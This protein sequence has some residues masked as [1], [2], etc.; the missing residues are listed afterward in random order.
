[1]PATVPSTAEALLA[2]WAAALAEWGNRPAVLAA[3]GS[4]ARTFAEVEDEAQARAADFAALPPRSIV[5]VQIGNAPDWPAVFL[6]LLRTNHLTLPLG[7]DLAPPPFADALFSPARRLTPLPAA[8]LSPPPTAVL[9]KL[10]SGTTGA[11]R[12]VW[13]TA[14]QLAADCAQICATMGITRGDV[15]FGA[16][17]LAHSYGFS[18]LLT[19]LLLR[20]VPLALSEDRLPR[21]LLAGLERTGATVF[22]GTPVLFQHLAA[23][24]VPRPPR[25]RLCISAGAPLPRATWEAFHARFGLGIHT[26][27][28]SSECGGIAYDRSGSLVGEGHVGTALEGV[29]LAPRGDGRLEV[30]S[31]AVGG[32]YF[33][34]ADPETL[35]GSRF[36]PGDLVRLT[37][38]GL[39]LTGRAGDLIN[40][41]GRK[42]N[43]A[44]VER[45][46]VQFPGVRA[47]VVF[48]VVS[49]RRGEEPVVCVAGDGIDPAALLRHCLANLPAWQAPRD[50]WL[51]P[52]IPADERGKT[53]RRRLA[54]RYRVRA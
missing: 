28:G 13:F 6:A 31:A 50:V 2:P 3:D 9:L 39:V 22:P 41:A 14:V 47:A 37:E 29:S 45:C 7:G 51:V 53:S 30:R 21:A 10:T 27:Y 26:F 34:E 40:V 49:P 1:M 46:V 38:H 42:L 33:P 23:L 48:G 4:V 19:P 25:L 16:I 17:P 8:R 11:P 24:D 36:V 18:N 15:N 44:D 54:E 35:D 5:A 52:E 20:G 32:G 43:P 12:A